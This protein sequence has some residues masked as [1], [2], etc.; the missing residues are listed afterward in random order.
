M[1]LGGIGDSHSASMHQVTTCMHSHDTEQKVGAAKLTSPAETPKLDLRVHQEQTQLSFME[2]VQQLLQNGR[3][4]LLGFWRGNDTSFQS[5][6]GEKTVS[7]QV[8]AQAFAESDTSV[9]KQQ[10]TLHSNP[11]FAAIEPE[12]TTN[13]GIPIFQKVKLKVKEATGQLTGQL[14][15]HL[16]NKFFSFQKQGSFHAKKEGRR[17]DLRKRSKYREDQLEIDCVLTDESYLL[18]SYDRKGAY[19]QLTTRK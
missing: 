10:D 15:K 3:Q 12:K 14:A 9:K 16:P 6:S 8:M 18:D 1:Q 5:E 4:R 2:W 17:E 19:S 11:Y 13:A 7:G